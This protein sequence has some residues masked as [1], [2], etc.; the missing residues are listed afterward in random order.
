MLT[1]YYHYCPKFIKES[2]FFF[3]FFVSVINDPVVGA[4]YNLVHDNYEL[5]IL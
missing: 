1:L 2:I 4:C 3:S 5:K